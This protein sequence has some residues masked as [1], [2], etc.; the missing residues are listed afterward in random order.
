M[1]IIPISQLEQYLLKVI[2]DC[3]NEVG[4]KVQE[5]F[6]KHVQTDVYDV[7]SYLGR[8]NYYD[9]AGEPTGQLME[10]VINTKPVVSGNQVT[11]E[12][13]HDSDLMNVNPNTFLHGSNYWNPNDV[14][15]MLPY[16]INEGK[17]G[18]LFGAVWEGLKRPYI[19]NT[20]EELVSKDLVKKWMIEAL[21]KRGIKTA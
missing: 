15:D 17:T 14:R 7:G 12:I 13:K 19:T 16:L 2:A 10:S 20:Y 4:Q 1:P 5:L 9:G 6:K 18:G 8:N 3:M 21:K 11:T